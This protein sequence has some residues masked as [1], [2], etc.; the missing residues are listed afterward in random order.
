MVYNNDVKE[1]SER[2]KKEYEFL[3]KEKTNAL[4][5]DTIVKCNYSIYV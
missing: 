4:K 2:L 5:Y 1:E 3:D